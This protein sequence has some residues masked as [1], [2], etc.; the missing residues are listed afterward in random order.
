MSRLTAVELRRLFSRRLVLAAMVAALL[1]GGLVLLTTWTSTRPMTGAQVADAERAYEQQLADW[2]E[3]GAE[4]IAQCEE[5]QERER[6]LTG[7][8]LDFGCQDMEPQREWFFAEPPPLEDTISPTLSTFSALLILVAVAIGATFFAA[9]ISTGAITS[10]LTFEPRRTRVYASKLAAAAI[11]V[12]PV[13]VLALALV[14]LG[15]W[16]IHD[17]RGLTGTMTR[18][19]WLDVGWML[20]RIVAIAVAA[21]LAGAA[22]GALLRHT[23]AVLGLVVGY[24]AVVEG[25]LGSLAP[26]ARPWLLQLNVAGWIDGGTT[27]YTPGCADAAT[28]G[29]CETVLTLG[30]SAVYL[31]VLLAVIVLVAGLVFRRRDVT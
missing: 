31:A 24:L 10:W 20:V 4:Q 21:A 6:E 15:I 7:Q 23:A 16:W 9:E 3:N 27:Y 25:I 13:T 30:Q 1:V 26:A 17:L 19:A 14:T 5:D 11:G 2:E 29:M 18:A 22:L 8:D 28:G 12:V